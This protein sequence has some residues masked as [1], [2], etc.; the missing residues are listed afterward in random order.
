MK[1]RNKLFVLVAA[2]FMAFPLVGCDQKPEVATKSE[3]TPTA[4]QAATY[5]YN[6][7]KD[8]IGA[9]TSSFYMVSIVTI[10]NTVFDVTYTVKPADGAQSG[11][12]T[13]G[14]TNAEEH[15]TAIIVKYADSTKKNEYSLVAKLKNG[16]DEATR[17]I[18]GYYVPTF[19]SVTVNELIT[20]GKAK[21][22]YALEGYVVALNANAGSAGSFVL[23][24]QA[25]DCVFSYDTPKFDISTKAS[26][27]K[28]G[29]KV[30]IATGI[31]LY[32]DNKF[33]QM[34]APAVLKIEDGQNDNK[35]FIS[36]HVHEY[37]IAELKADDKK[38]EMGATPTSISKQ[39][40]KITGGFAVKN[41]N[42]TVLSDKA[43]GDQVINL[44]SKPNIDSSLVGQAVDVYGVV[45]GVSSKGALT[46][47]TYAVVAAGSQVF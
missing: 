9:T 29:Q 42:Y 20:N 40:L 16:S 19:S 35:T 2:G 26:G 41:G 45:R 31:S 3:A 30:T 15:Q 6:V 23:M 44:Y 38:T 12:V 13:V 28:L 36:E 39:F 34:S 33:P 10:K 43:D 8:N 7:Y 4:A 25:G 37:T 22:T 18:K 17:E 24:D 46:V 11:I 21:E 27:L 47:Q 5:L 32:G 1:L 14:D